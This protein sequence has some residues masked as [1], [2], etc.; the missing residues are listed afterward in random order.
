MF[1]A[2]G[3]F[4]HCFQDQASTSNILGFVR[5]HIPRKKLFTHAEKHHK[6]LKLETNISDGFRNHASKG[7]QGLSVITYF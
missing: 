5:A 2:R 3:N 1:P 7:I 6:T 4:T